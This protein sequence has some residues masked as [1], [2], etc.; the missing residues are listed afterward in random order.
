VTWLNDG[1]KSLQVATVLPNRGPQNIIKS[2][3]LNQLELLFTAATAY[4]PATSSDSTDAAFTLPFAFPVD[5]SALEQTITV[6]FRG[7]SFARLMLPKSSSTTDVERRIIHLKFSNVPFAAF[8]DQRETFDDFVA[9]TTPGK[10]ETL[11]LSGAANA[12]A[13]TAVGLLSLSDIG[14]SVDS[15][16][17]GLQGL[18]TRPVTVSNLDVNHGFP[19]YLLI[20]VDTSI[21][22][23]R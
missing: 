13:K 8:D 4:G 10:E 18:A 6:G 7:Q 14:F 16:V 11:R 19:H 9:A 17:E 3:S 21:F 20:R 1:I 2:I 23:P 12:D 22:N 5:I 15:V